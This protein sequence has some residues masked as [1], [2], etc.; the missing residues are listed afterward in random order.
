MKIAVLVKLKC[1]SESIEIDED[2]TYVIRIKQPPLEGKANK[3]II[4]MLSKYLSVPKSRITLVSGHKTK[5]KKFE[6]SE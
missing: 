5:S 4:E 1:K 6:V 2:G 3:R